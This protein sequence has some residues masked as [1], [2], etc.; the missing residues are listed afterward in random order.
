MLY[1]EAY[2]CS[3]PSEDHGSDL[4][5]LIQKHLELKMKV[6]DG[7]RH[8]AVEGILEG[9]ENFLTSVITT[10]QKAS[11]GEDESEALQSLLAL[12]SHIQ[13]I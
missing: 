5:A 12:K 3:D 8:Q 6:T 11:T 13:K 9:A 7:D 1:D 10:H 2:K 4:Q